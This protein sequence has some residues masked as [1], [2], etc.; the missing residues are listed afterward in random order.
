MAFRKWLPKND[1]SRHRSNSSSQRKDKVQGD[2]SSSS[3]ALKV[4]N[5]HVLLAD[6]KSSGSELEGDGCKQ[7]DK[8]YNEEKYDASPDINKLQQC[9]CGQDDVNF[10]Q[11]F[12]GDAKDTLHELFFPGLVT[13][14]SEHLPCGDGSTKVF[15]LENFGNTC[16]CNSVL[17]C[18]FNLSELR[19]NI[20]MYPIR[21]D[22]ASRKPKLDVVGLKPR[23][24]TEAGLACSHSPCFSKN[25][26]STVTDAGTASANAT[27]NADAND[28]T[29]SVDSLGGS[30][31]NVSP[32]TSKDPFKRSSLSF[33]KNN[34]P[35]KDKEIAA[36]LKH[37]SSS[38][39]VSGNDKS[40]RD[41]AESKQNIPFL[42]SGSP[43]PE[44]RPDGAHLSQDQILEKLHEGYTRIVVGR[45][46]G[47]VAPQ[48]QKSSTTLFSTFANGRNSSTSSSTSTTSSATTA[49]SNYQRTP[50]ASSPIYLTGPSSE[51]RKKA[52]LISGPVLNIDHPLDSDYFPSNTEPNLYSSLKDVFECIV[53]SRSMLGVVSP[54]QLVNVLRKEN[55]LF[56]STMHQDA[57]EFFNFLMNSL[58]EFIQRQ[59]EQ[60]QTEIPENFVQSLFQGTMIN[61][62]KC[63][64]CDNVTSSDELFLDFAI[65]VNEDE[66]VNIQDMLSNFNQREMLNGAN[67]FYCDSCN[68]LQEAERT[69]GLKQLPK[70]LSLHLKR[71]K[72]SEKH[73][74]N[75]KLFNKIYYPL[76]L[77]VCTKSDTI[78]CKNY[79]LNG[80]VI[81]MGGGPQHGHYVAICKHDMF[82]WLLYDDETVESID[83][84]TVFKFVGDEKDMTTAYVLFF[85]EVDPNNINVPVDYYHNVD[86]LIKC[87]EWVRRKCS[88]SANV[89]SVP[90][91]EVPEEKDNCA[92]PTVNSSSTPKRRSKLFSFRRSKE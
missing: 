45:T 6:C 58:G 54:V 18:L 85:K 12:L 34:D 39:E 68:G 4:Q 82:G 40:E 70:I 72:Y 5:S 46:T 16:Y 64:T 87:D 24:F 14:E 10:I 56:D 84:E 71:F 31:Q 74:S 41:S 23:V 50:V 67:K 65:P 66:E 61:S 53:E 7:V 29:I 59:L 8:K 69:V 26:N 43:T 27:P 47:R 75:I 81:H 36:E 76:K 60:T 92:A 48:I 19:T 28:K 77:K 83:E 79:E 80:I 51:Q 33:F 22:P 42:P 89:N 90:I 15:G 63:L 88:A 3:V 55:I 57:H 25:G 2:L 52:A 9:L 32:V 78:V 37:N 44:D 30:S 62:I 20:L 13:R 11:Q 73:Q 49:N 21:K 38:N 91:E 1:K 86:Q 17:Q 35:Q